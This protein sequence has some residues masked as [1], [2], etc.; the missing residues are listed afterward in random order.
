MTRALR[1]LV[2]SSLMVATPSLAGRGAAGMNLVNNTGQAISNLYIRR[3]GT[4]SWQP[5]PAS[6]AKPAK[7]AKAVSPFADPDCAFDLKVTLEDSKEAVWGGVN[8]CEV[9]SLTLNRS[10]AGVT[11]VDYD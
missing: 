7:G 4:T 8:L 6:P 3:T 9:K 11:W 2:L 10:E 1:I 5:L